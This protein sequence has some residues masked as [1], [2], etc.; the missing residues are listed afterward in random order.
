M[1]RIIDEVRKAA[2]EVILFVDELHTLVG[3]GAAGAIDPR[4][5][6]PALARGELSASARR[7]WTSIAST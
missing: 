4:I 1:K 5:C 3:A 6:E 2:G 7:P